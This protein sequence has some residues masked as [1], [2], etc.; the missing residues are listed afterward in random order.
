MD[1]ISLRN[2]CLFAHHGAVSAEREA[3]QKLEF[4]IELGGSF[5]GAAG[6]DSLSAAVDYTQVYKELEQIVLSRRFHLLESL[7]DEIARSILPK[8]SLEVVKV[9][10]RKRNVPF[11]GSDSYV[12]VARER[13]RT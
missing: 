9:T 13:R 3:G 10:V 11:A 8:F 5:N 2:V 1:R 7:A 6:E 12:E 4:D